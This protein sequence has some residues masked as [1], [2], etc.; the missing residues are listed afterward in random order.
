MTRKTSMNP[1]PGDLF[2]L[3]A[4]LMAGAAMMAVVGWAHMR[5]MQAFYGAICGSDAGLLAHCPACYGAVS[6]FLLSLTSY[7]LARRARSSAVV[8][9]S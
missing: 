5:A 7:G 3:S 1:R 2:A 8:S 4:A 9:R 6:L